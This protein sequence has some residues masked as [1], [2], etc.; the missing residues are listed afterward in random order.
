ME[1]SEFIDAYSVDLIYLLEARNALLTHPLRNDYVLQ[2]NLDASFCRLLAVFM[3]G[4]IEAMLME[5]RDRDHAKILES[6]FAKDVHNGDRVR[7][8]CEA[9]Q[10][11]GIQVDTE[12]FDDYLA[13]KYLRNTIVH[14]KWKPSEKEWLD[15]RRFSTDTRK[16][17]N[18]HLRRIEDVNQNMMLYIALTSV[19]S[20]KT[21]VTPLVVSNQPKPQKLVKLPK[22]ST[23]RSDETGILKAHDLDRIIWNNLERISSVLNTAIENVSISGSYNWTAGREPTEIEALDSEER[24]RL[25][26]VSARRAS[27]ENS[28]LFAKYREFAHEALI[29]W[30]E[31][32]NRVVNGRGLDEVKIKAALEV[33][34]NSENIAP[35]ADALGSGRL[36]YELFPNIMPVSLLTLY[37]PIVDPDATANYL[38][39]AERALLAFRLTRIWYSLVERGGHSV[40]NRFEFYDRIRADFAVT[41]SL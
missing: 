9:F 26:Y 14:G 32:W 29:F 41:R 7:N 31:Y 25:F 17:T 28:Q 11:A 20:S 33:L 15:K 34:L 40:E 24:K 39:E 4:S 6:Y 1:I 22:I 5:W 16:L 8:L 2:P 13:I 3:V 38:R 35:T 23:Q 18:E 21:T 27:E 12:I 19:V 30:R 36:A 10:K 37:L